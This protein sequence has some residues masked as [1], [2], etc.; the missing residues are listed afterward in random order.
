MCAGTE[1]VAS[2]SADYK[3]NKRF[4]VYGGVMYSRLFD[5]LYIN[6]GYLHN[7]AISP[8]VGARFQF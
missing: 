8:M 4:D 5:G 1:T 2:I 3:F 6:N 7:N